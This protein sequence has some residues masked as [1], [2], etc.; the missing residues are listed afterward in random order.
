MTNQF[1]EVHESNQNFF[2]FGPGS[3]DQEIKFAQRPLTTAQPNA[4]QQLDFRYE[5]AF[6]IAKV[7]DVSAVFTSEYSRFFF[8]WIIVPKRDEG[9]YRDI[10]CA[11]KSLIGEYD[12]IHFDFTIMPSGN[13]D[14]REMVT[15]PTAKLIFVRD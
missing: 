9:V 13:K 6:K 12:S 14:P 3:E 10:F 7:P 2:A 11:E 5:V 8:V 1:I 15:D 4:T